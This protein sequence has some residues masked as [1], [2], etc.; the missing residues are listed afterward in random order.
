MGPFY[1]WHETLYKLFLLLNM[2]KTIAE[3]FN[4]FHSWLTPTVTESEKAKKHRASIKACIE[5]NFGLNRFFR[6]GS[7][8]NGTSISSYSDVDYFAS[9]PR[10][11]LKQNSS[12]TLQE[13]KKVLD[14]RF[15]STGIRIDAPA[16][17]APF[18]DELAETTEIV[19]ADFL[20][21]SERHKK[22]VYD[23]PDGL[24]GWMRSSPDSHNYYVDYYNTKLNKKLKPLIRFIKAWKYY[25]DVPISS[26]YLEIFVTRYA[27]NEESIVYSIDTKS[28]F[29]RLQDS[30]LADISDPMGISGNIRACV[31]DEK[32][33]DVLTKLKRAVDRSS[34]AVSAENASRIS[35]AFDWW[36]KVY[37]DCFPSYY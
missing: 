24:G 29:K 27:S 30:L 26:F 34:N 35:D 18:G 21:L 7:F 11:K 9:I 23:I 20:Y 19:P 17:V 14:S 15:P 36:N 10:D 3:G 22:N 32:K 6:T 1:Y 8:G 12:L 16:V 4:T 5:A 25:R 13:L 37:N 2:A 28:I 33:T 31:N